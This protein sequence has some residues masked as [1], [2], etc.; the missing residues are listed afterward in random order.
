[1]PPDPPKP[2]DA[3]TEEFCTL[4]GMTSMGLSH[5][6]IVPSDV[7]HPPKPC[8]RPRK[9]SN[10]HSGICIRVKSPPSASAGAG[11]ILKRLRSSKLNGKGRSRNS[12]RN[13]VRVEGKRS[14]STPL[15]DVLTKVIEKISADK[16]VSSQ[17]K[18][19]EGSNVAHSHY[20]KSI[21]IDLRRSKVHLTG[22]ESLISENDG[23][24]INKPIEVVSSDKGVGDNQSMGSDKVDIQEDFNMLDANVDPGLVSKDASSHN[25]AGEEHV[26]DE[27]I[28]KTNKDGG[29]GVQ[30]S[31]EFVFGSKNGVSGILNK[32]PV[33]LNSVHFGPSLFHRN[34]SSNVW[35]SKK[36]GVNAVNSDGSLN[37]ESFAEKMKKGAED[38]ELLMQYVLQSVSKLVDELP[39]FLEISYP[40][41][42][43]RPAKVGKLDVK[44]QWKP[45]LCTH[46][47]TFGHATIA[48]K[49]RPRSEEELAAKTAFEA[50]KV[51]PN[52]SKNIAGVDQVDDGFKVM[53]KK[54][55]PVNVKTNEVQ[56]NG[57]R[58]N[59]GGRDVGSQNRKVQN[60]GRLGYSNNGASFNSQRRFGGVMQR[61]IY[62]QK[63]NNAGG[64]KAVQNKADGGIVEKPKLASAYDHNFRP[65]VLVRGSGSGKYDFNLC[66]ENFP[67]SNSFD[68][69]GD[70][71]MM[72]KEKA[73]EEA[74]D[75]EYIN[76]IWPK[77]KQ[78]VINVM[79]TGIY[80]S[81][82]IRLGWSL[83]Q[84]DFSIITV[85][86]R[87]AGSSSF[88]PGMVDFRECL[89][90][91]GV[92]DLVMSGLK[93]TWNKS[94]VKVDGLLKK[95]DRVMSNLPF[96]EMF[97][98]A[99]AQFLPFVVSDHTP[100]V[101]EIPVLPRAKPRPFKF[102]NFLAK[103]E[104]FLPIVKDVWER[105][106]PGH[107]MFSVISKLKLLK[108]P[109]RKLKFAQG[110][111]TRKLWRTF[112]KLIRLESA[113]DSLSYIVRF[114]CDRPINRSVWSILQRENV[115]LRLLSLKI[116]S[117]SQAKEAA[118]M[119]M[120]I[121]EV[122]LKFMMPVLFTGVLRSVNFCS[123]CLH[124]NPVWCEPS[125]D[126]TCISLYLDVHCVTDCPTCIRDSNY[127]LMVVISLGPT[128][129]LLR[130]LFLLFSMDYFF[131]DM[132][133]NCILVGVLND[134][135]TLFSFPGF[136]P[137]GF[138]LGWFL[139]RQYCL[140][141]RSTF[142]C[143]EMVSVLKLMIMSP[144]LKM[145]FMDRFQAKIN[146]I[147]VQNNKEQ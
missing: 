100:A 92:E 7:N 73:V 91:I 115:R 34:G 42:G 65:K 36:A 14:I 128:E 6:P 146:K 145:K 82:A 102:V 147:Q 11:S 134:S 124:V 28:K 87:S 54:N 68:V 35:A 33:V 39:S 23:S 25:V 129:M 40:P 75:E 103:N 116:R 141:K 107:A 83:Q 37:I 30:G 144:A 62:Q 79:E 89:G 5:K 113:P 120:V 38:R 78:E 20:S 1:M 74:M 88:T 15:D 133:T 80:P 55:R 60:N 119:F 132:K 97:A 90:E 44:Y 81:K 111:L 12:S 4:T 21:M 24:F 139:R 48:C 131:E 138:F 63:G 84:T 123:W 99:N 143:I 18:F 93:F 53:G 121:W 76:V 56:G 8:G 72:D 109:L 105:H 130:S 101:V 64:G 135:C 69:L 50:A 104:E 98:N 9:A 126:D 106:I 118:G 57:G 125:S 77:L 96:V 58:Q 49:I 19:K 52:V 122:V 43:N 3:I 70:Q 140:V 41:L 110:D 2:P 10:S 112:K 95:L 108:K 117:S 45:P 71:E 67:A 29:G 13:D 22:N 47:K 142:D 127:G 17:M 137:D 27:N 136:C 46:C 61:N 85:M 16:V 51:N 32:P 94:R 114:V 26:R 86:E 31:F 59:R 66:N